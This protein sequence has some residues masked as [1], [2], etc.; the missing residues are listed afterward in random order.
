MQRMILRLKKKKKPKTT[1]D[2][3]ETLDSRKLAGRLTQQPM[4]ETA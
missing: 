2:K 3:E 4:M 1:I